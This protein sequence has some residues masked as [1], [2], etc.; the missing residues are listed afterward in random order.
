[1]TAAEPDWLDLRRPVDDAARQKSLHLIDHAVAR[2][3]AEAE[4]DE[5]R[6]LAIDIGAGTG[7]SAL[8]FDAAL[9]AR[10]PDWELNWILLDSDQASLDYAAAALPHARTICAPIAGL[11]TLSSELLA[12]SEFH[13]SRLLLTCSAL[14]DVLTETDLT[15]VVRS[16]DDH[17]GLGLFLLSI[18]DGW[19]LDP[20]HPSDAVIDA[21]FTAHQ[22]RDGRL[23]HHAP[24]RLMDLARRHGLTA[25]EGPSP[26]R[27][28]APADRTFLNR[29]L[30]ERLDAAVDERPGLSAVAEDWWTQRQKQLGSGLSVRVDHLDVLIDAVGR[31]CERETPTVRAITTPTGTETT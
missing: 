19:E 23:G 27:L 14:L 12:A 8:W 15:A 22:H 2:L 28:A 25:V 6:L 20:D 4:S 17:D 10:L 5:K 31:A 29:F 13:G 3:S 30:S 24:E 11:P 9:R 18:V 1:M 21:A 7:N 26:W 16:L